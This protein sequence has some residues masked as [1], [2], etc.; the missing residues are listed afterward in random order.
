MCCPELDSGYFSIVS[1]SQNEEM[2]KQV[3]HDSREGYFQM[4]VLGIDT[5]TM[6]GSVGLIDDDRPLGEYSLSIEVTHSERLM[7]A[8]AALMRGVRMNLDAVDG[9]ALSIGPG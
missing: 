3:Q 9:F 6:M 4:K 8:G 7:E 2:L 1:G 5:S